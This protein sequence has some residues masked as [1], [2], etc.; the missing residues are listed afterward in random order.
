M[1]YAK[2]SYELI[3]QKK[4]TESIIIENTLLSVYYC[5]CTYVNSMS[6]G[7]DVK[8][9]S[10]VQGNVPSCARKR[11]L[12]QISL[13]VGSRAAAKAK[14]PIVA[15]SFYIGVTVEIA[16]VSIC[17]DHFLSKLYSFIDPDHHLA[18]AE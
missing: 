5:F 9:R 10:R 18:K 11:S 7:R 17:T 14:F 12:L 4:F 15:F 2:I 16:N 6:F 1:I 13:R 8:P 3:L